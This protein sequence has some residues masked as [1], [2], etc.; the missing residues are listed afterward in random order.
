MR[1]SQDIK[2]QVGMIVQATHH[3]NGRPFEDPSDDYIITE[4]DDEKIQGSHIKINRPCL[5]A[6]IEEWNSGIL[7]ITNYDDYTDHIVYEK[8]CRLDLIELE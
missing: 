6:F 8:Y 4:I 1:T 2:P 3:R 5:I 7:T